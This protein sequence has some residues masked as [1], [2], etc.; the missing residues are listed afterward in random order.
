M[1]ADRSA[2]SSC[3]PLEE[4]PERACELQFVPIMGKRTACM[5]TPAG[6]LAIRSCLSCVRGEIIDY[7]TM[8]PLLSRLAA[9]RLL[10]TLL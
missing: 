4:L 6:G 3:Y 9:G 7:L 2:E 10:A 5:N 8:Q 1:E